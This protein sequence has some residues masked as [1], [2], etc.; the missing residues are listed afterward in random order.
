VRGERREDGKGTGGK[1]RK[2][3][4]DKEKKKPS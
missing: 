3:N 1:G 2:E 4:N